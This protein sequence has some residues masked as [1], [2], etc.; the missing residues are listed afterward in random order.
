MAVAAQEA[1]PGVRV[2]D[3]YLTPT[4]TPTLIPTKPILICLI[5]ISFR[6]RN[7]RYVFVVDL[8]TIIKD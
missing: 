7:I 6:S 8:P 4:T 3:Q 5:M 1:V 2:A